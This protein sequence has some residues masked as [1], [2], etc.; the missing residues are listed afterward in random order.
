M[1]SSTEMPDNQPTRQHAPKMTGSE[2]V[3]LHRDRKAKDML[4]IE[5]ELYPAERDSLIR[6]G[7]L[8][9]SK[10]GSK[11]A[12][13]D[14]LEQFLEKNLDQPQPKQVEWPLGEWKSGTGGGQQ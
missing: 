14:A 3:R 12:V 7:L 4:L 5:I 9:K 11:D 2:R 13:R 1:I 10:R 6:R 8:H